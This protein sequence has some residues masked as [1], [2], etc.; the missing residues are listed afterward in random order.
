VLQFTVDVQAR[1][2]E[3]G[4]W[5]QPTQGLAAAA[6]AAEVGTHQPQLT[7]QSS[8]AP[9][10]NTSRPNSSAAGAA[11]AAAPLCAGW[12]CCPLVLVPGGTDDVQQMNYFIMTLRNSRGDMVSSLVKQLKLY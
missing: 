4:P 9:L 12:D 11:A 1:G 7:L 6:A 8:A 10:S 5:Q 2:F 3:T